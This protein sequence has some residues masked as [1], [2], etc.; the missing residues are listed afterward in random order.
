MIKT[1]ARPVVSMRGR[2]IYPYNYRQT[3]YPVRDLI[4]Q[5]SQKYDHSHT[6]GQSPG[7]INHEKYLSVYLG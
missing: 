2:G 5:I 6:E 4:S 7:L 3:L 1:R